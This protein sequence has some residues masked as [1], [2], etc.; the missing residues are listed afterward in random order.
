MRAR[1]V[2]RTIKMFY[3]NCLA[4][5]LQ[6]NETDEVT[7]RMTDIKRTHEKTLVAMNEEAGPTVKYLHIFSVQEKKEKY[8]MLESTFL[9]HATQVPGDFDDEEDYDE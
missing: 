2:T 5:D 7:V 1:K 8:E 9:E 3:V 6:T 4:L